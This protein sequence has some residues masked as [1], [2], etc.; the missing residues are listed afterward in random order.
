[1]N[2]SLA[3]MRAALA[4]AAQRVRRRP[5]TAVAAALA[6]L[7]LCVL[8]LPEAAPRPQVRGTGMVDKGTLR[9]EFSVTGIIKPEEGAE[10]KTGS[11]FTGVIQTLNVKLGDPVTKG[12]IIAE[13]DAR[14]QKAE[15]LKLEATLRKLRA[16]LEIAEQT[17]PL[18]I[19]ETEAL[20]AS[21]KA[22]KD[23]TQ[24]NLKR[25]SS[26]AKVSGVSQNDAEKAR[27]AADMAAALFAQHQTAR[28]RL[29]A[30]YGLRTAYLKEAIAESEAELISA[31][32]RLSY[33]TIVS[34]MDGVVSE[35][36]AQEG[37][38][39]VAGFQVAYLVTV[40]DPRR[41]ELRMFVDE[42]DIGQVG[43][44]SRV[45][46]TVEA[47]PHKT[48]EGVVDLIHPGPEIRNNIVYYRALLRLAPETALQ[49]RPE[50]TAR[51]NI[52][53]AEKDPVLLVP[54]TAF[55]W[56][57]NKR[58]VFVVD[59]DSVR[60]VTVRTGLAGLSYTEVVEGLAQGQTVATSLD[61]PTPL[62][63]EWLQ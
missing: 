38:T 41:M 32:A 40:L 48:F 17:Y 58:V 20:M 11:R 22:E 55:K 36:T 31:D 12:Q 18:Q 28:R 33:A 5:K 25:M 23:Y 13:L 16:E 61:L 2:T 52:L 63:K 35:I 43:V 7:V 6:L 59:G 34:P 26:L 62:P 15:C 8:L 44:G 54:N 24:R 10:V 49:L 47:F 37:E 39:L 57:G 21:A 53:V 1:M 45:T 60:P 56:L 3:S 30:E 42:N 19:K 9:K 4:A 14:E 46:F 51:C 50:M 27:Q 29:E